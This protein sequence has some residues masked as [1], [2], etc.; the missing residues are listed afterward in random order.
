MRLY[1][2]Y[3]T[4]LRYIRNYIAHR[5]DGTRKNF[6]TVVRKFY[7]AVVPGVTSG[8]LLLSERVSRPSLLETHI[9]TSRILIRDLVKA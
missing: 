5:N 3:I 1:A 4:E 9:R 6:R 2:S 7:G 8:T